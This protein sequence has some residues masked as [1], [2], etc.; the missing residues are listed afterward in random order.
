M[1]VERFD[2]LEEVSLFLKG[3]GTGRTLV[4]KEGRGVQLF[5]VSFQVGVQDFAA[6]EADSPA[7]TRLHL[8]QV[9][10]PIVV[11]SQQSVAAAAAVPAAT[12][13][14]EH[15]YKKQNE[16]KKKKPSAKHSFFG[17]KT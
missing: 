5:V 14:T 6:E 8:G 15:I 17:L 11:P 3:P 12:A 13:A 16:R 1:G 10:G 4:H 9:D 7:R 2:V